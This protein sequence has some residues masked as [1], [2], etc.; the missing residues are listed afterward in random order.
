MPRPKKPIVIQKRKESKSYIL[1]LNTTSGLP[2]RICDEWKRKSFQNFPAELALHSNPKSKSAAETAAQALIAFLKKKQEEGNARHVA[3]ENITVCAWIEKFTTIETSPRTGINA[4][5]NRPYSS[6]TL[7]NYRS[8]YEHHI[9]NDPFGELKM[10]DVEEEDV[11]EFTTRLSLKKLFDGRLM[12][13]TRT[14]VG[15]IV[16]IRMTFQVYQRRNRRWLN[17]F[18]NL[19]P[20][21]YSS[22]NRDA[23]TEEELIKLFSPKVLKTSLEVA[24]CAVMFLAGLRRSEIF[25]LKPECLDWSTPKIIVKNAW[26]NFDSK[27]RVMGPPKSKKVRYAPFD[28]FLQDAIKKLWE[29]NGKHEFVFS[30]VKG[31]NKKVV[32]PGP[33]WIRGRFKKWLA[34][35][36]I[37]LNGRVIVPHCSRHSLATI[38]EN[39]GEPLRHIQE[40]LDHANMKTTK[41]YLHSTS[42]TIRDIGTKINGILENTQEPK[43]ETNIVSFVKTG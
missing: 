10:A 21:K 18:Q 33:S 1:T 36:G 31:K 20:P 43:M 22:I 9:K 32:T 38:L 35:A 11:L 3:I 16:F 28:K 19:D 37:E 2:K 42:K 30:Y 40:L 8:Y 7:C 6:D 14:F 23:L 41:Q 12:V 34:D 5:R 17:P 39:H 29:E 13:G 27:D 26:Q 24:I 15:V 4:S 25:A